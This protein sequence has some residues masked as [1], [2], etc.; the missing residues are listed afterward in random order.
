MSISATFPSFTSFHSS[1]NSG[2]R[3]E[4]ILGDLI[5]LFHD[6]AGLFDEVG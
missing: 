5:L 2:K 3:K 4:G 6:A 1:V